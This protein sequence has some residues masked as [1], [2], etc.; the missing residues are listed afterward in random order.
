MQSTQQALWVCALPPPDSRTWAVWLELPGLAF[1]LA[2]PLGT[3][4]GLSEAAEETCWDS[5]FI[6]AQNLLFL[7]NEHVVTLSYVEGVGHLTHRGIK[8]LDALMRFCTSVDG[9]QRREVAR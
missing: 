6:I 4:Q 2:C 9:L 3:A 7:Y 1:A 8:K 5:D